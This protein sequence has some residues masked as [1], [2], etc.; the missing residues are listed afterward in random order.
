MKYTAK[1]QTSVAPCSFS[2][3]LRAY[4][5]CSSTA[6]VL[7]PC[8]KINKLRSVHPAT[9]WDLPNAGGGRESSHPYTCCPTAIFA[10]TKWHYA[11]SSWTIAAHR[12]S[13]ASGD[14]PSKAKNTYLQYIKEDLNAPEN[15]KTKHYVFRTEKCSQWAEAAANIELR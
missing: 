12:W 6:S 4:A 15:Y 8:G 13:C 2:R 9:G 1:L 3:Y 7:Q 14:K 10:R 5:V 11:P